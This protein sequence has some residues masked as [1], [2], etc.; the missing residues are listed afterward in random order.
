MYDNLYRYFIDNQHTLSHQTIIIGLREL[1]II[2]FENYCLNNFSITNPMII[3]NTSSNFS[4][5]YELRLYTSGCYYIDM[6]NDWKTDGLLVGPLT[7]ISQTQCFS[8]SSNRITTAFN[9]L[10]ISTDWNYVFANADFIQN[11]T[12]YLTIICICTIFLILMIYAH[13]QDKKD[14][15]KV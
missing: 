12:I 11:K 13:Y 2:E 7:T 5:D 4:S 3:F 9:L 1:T 10:P 15:E 8:T 6:N 14:V